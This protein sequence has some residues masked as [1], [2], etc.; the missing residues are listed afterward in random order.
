MPQIQFDCPED[1]DDKLKHYMID[2]KIIDKRIAVIE[3][4]KERLNKK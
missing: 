2:K 4:L 1:I 3:I